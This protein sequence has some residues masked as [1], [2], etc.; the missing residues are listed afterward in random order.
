[1][2]RDDLVARGKRDIAWIE[3]AGPRCGEVMSNR[4]NTGD[5]MARIRR[6]PVV[7]GCVVECRLIEYQRVQAF[8]TAAF[9]ILVLT[10]NPRPAFSAKAGPNAFHEH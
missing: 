10:S 5:G 2:F 4:S 1:M 8:V 9:W 7:N 6:R 3:R